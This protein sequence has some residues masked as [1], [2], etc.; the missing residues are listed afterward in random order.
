MSNEMC[1]H[2]LADCKL[3]TFVKD[4]LKHAFYTRNVQ[5]TYNPKPNEHFLANGSLSI[6]VAKVLFLKYWCGR[7]FCFSSENFSLKYQVYFCTKSPNQ[8][9]VLKIE[10]HALLT[11]HVTA[12]GA[13]GSKN[14]SQYP[15]DKGLG[16]PK[17]RSILCGEEKYPFRC[18][19]SN[20]C[21]PHCFQTL[22]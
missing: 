11:M 6:N 21:Y 15:F 7:R 12:L 4:I 2:Y 17:S 19:K 3:C 20:P 8:K 22:H 1:L 9:N 16:G 5:N 18:R 10:F 14:I 13:P